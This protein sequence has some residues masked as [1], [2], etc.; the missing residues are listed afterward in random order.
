MI[1]DGIGH[2][3]EQLQVVVEYHGHEIDH[4]DDSGQQPPQQVAGHQ[5]ADDEIPLAVG[6]DQQHAAHQDTKHCAGIG[7]AHPGDVG[8]GQ[9]ETEPQPVPAA[10][11]R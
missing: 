6:H 1:A 8:V 11:H 7:T 4:I 5:R 9:E 2:L 10:E 3:A